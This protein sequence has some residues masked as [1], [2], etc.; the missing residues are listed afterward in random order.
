MYNKPKSNELANE[1]AGFLM[2]LGLN[3][4]LPTMSTLSVND[5]LSKVT[6]S[7]CN[8]VEWVITL[9][10]D[11]VGEVVSI[12]CDIKLLCQYLFICRVTK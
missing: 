2:G 11:N 3:G 8:R 4:H 9:T 6:K 12:N 5:Y 1:H 10:A 7:L